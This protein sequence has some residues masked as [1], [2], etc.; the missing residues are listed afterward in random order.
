[1]F[2]EAKMM[3]RSILLSL[4]VGL[5]CLAFSIP[6]TDGLIIHLDAGSL[7]GLNDGD[8]VTVWPDQATSDAVNGNVSVITGWNPPVYQSTAFDGNAAVRM[9]GGD[10]LAS[11]PLTLPNVNGGL[12]VF[13]V[14]QGDQS[15]QSA[16]RIMQLGSKA[17]TGGKCFGVDF[18]TDTVGADGG[19][20]ARFNN[21][22]SLVRTNN[23][24]TAGFHIAALQI[25]QGQTYGSLRYYVD[26]MTAE[27]YNNT[28]NQGNVVA[29]DAGGNELTIG[30]GIA[31][32]GSY[33]TS[34]DY[35]GDI[36][37]ILIYNSQ[38][39][40]IQMQQ[41]M[42]YLAAKY[43]IFQAWNPTPADG[44]IN[45]GVINGTKVDVSFG[46][47]T[48]VDP[49]NTSVPNPA[50]TKHYLYIQEGEP[51]FIGVTPLEIDAGVPV[52][53]TASA[54]PL[55]L[56][57]DA[58]YY[59]R[60]DESI[61]GSTADDPNTIT[62]PVWSFEGLKSIP[63]IL[64]APSSAVVALG[65][66]ATFSVE[67]TSLTT[68]QYAWYKTVDNSI[69]TPDDDTPAGTDADLVWTSVAASDEGYYYC[70]VTNESGESNA[71][72]TPVVTLGVAREVAHWTFDAA[73]LVGG[74]YQDV[75]GEG[76]HAEPNIVPTA[77]SF[78]DGVS[79]LKTAEAVDFSAETLTV[80]DAG[81]WAPS[82]Y[83][84]QFTFSAWVKWN[85]PNGAWQGVL[86]NRVT[87]AEA[88]FYIEIRQDNGNIQIGSPH[89]GSGDLVG[90]NLP[91][92]QWA[93]LVVTADRPLGVIIYINGMPVA[94]RV[95]A[96]D[97]PYAVLPLYVGSLGRTVSGALNNPFN[98]AFDD[99][100]IFNYAMDKFGVADLYYSVLE[101]PLCLNPDSVSLQF[102]VA[103]GGVNG[104]EPDCRVNLT[105]F[106]VFAETWLNCG[107]YPQSG[108]Y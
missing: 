73:D 52:Q 86:A 27:V 93:H 3:K 6:V 7:T 56:E 18:S 10:L 32:N 50:I 95:P 74:M 5:Q 51:N 16:E 55:S 81:D 65:E 2:W 38:L 45:Q 99:V 29:L 96:R 41:V 61:N 21:G 92:G 85:G 47:N 64:T 57:F 87:P 63:V 40:Q 108:C 23:P 97:I 9:Q 68:E 24:L 36:A 33:Y 66:P 1:M 82:A 22:K 89:F 35:H 14:A 37:E 72:F 19:S 106:A 71:Q 80:A 58:T 28:A 70:K 83:T 46:W 12:T 17:G 77:L 94:S 62:G 34:D 11:G 26:D 15:G 20:G 91:V 4:V 54:G 59:W 48:G 67:V 101:E 103:G 49:E 8:P 30:T 39:T 75:S 107:Y 60:V 31:T 44:A 102:D 42:D 76:H 13:I 98:G 100:R 78:V 25:G 105:D 43:S 69:A 88:N 84:G 79:P 53:A 90:T 104:D